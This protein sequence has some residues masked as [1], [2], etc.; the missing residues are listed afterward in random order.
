MPQAQLVLSASQAAPLDYVVPAAQEIVPLA[1]NAAFDGTSAAVTWYPALE[2]ISDSGHVVSRTFP[3][4]TVAAGGSAWVTFAP[5]LRGAAA[6]APTQ[7]FALYS[8]NSRTITQL[9]VSQPVGI[10]PP[11]FATNDAATFA[12]GS[13]TVGGIDYY[14]VRM[15]VEGWYLLI[16]GVALQGFTAGDSVYLSSFTGGG[17]Y[18]GDL[19][20]MQQQFYVAQPGLTTL[21]YID[22]EL[23]SAA[24]GTP[25]PTAPEIF[26]AKNGSGAR[27]TVAPDL[28]YIR[29]GGPTAYP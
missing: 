6:A 11:S 7:A 8:A 19:Q 3:E 28:L 17:S 12:I 20:G 24:A 23:V 14:G 2:L 5:F 16:I 27:G 26:Y 1:V 4:Q 9:G 22:A 18:F 10:G 25:A 15:L 29:L 21:S 13:T